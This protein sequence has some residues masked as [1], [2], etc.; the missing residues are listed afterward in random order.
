[1]SPAAIKA[2]GEREGMLFDTAAR[3][4]NLLDAARDRYPEDER[5]DV[6]SRILELV[7]EEDPE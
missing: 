5:E 4:R 3:I 2:R 7:S 6:E 1:V